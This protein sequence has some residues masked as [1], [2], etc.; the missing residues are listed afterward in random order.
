MVAKCN[1]EEVKGQ[2]SEKAELLQN[3]PE[4]APEAD[5][6]ETEE[7]IK[8]ALNMPGVDE[9]SID[10]S[11]EDDVLT[12]AAS[13]AEDA[14]EGMEEFYRGYREGVY[15]RSFSIMTE[16]DRD[17]IEAKMSNGVLRL[18][19]PKA[20]KPKPQKIAVAID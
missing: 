17:K 14:A 20:E 9:K 1:C 15:K 18:S 13:Q 10:L 12:I 19:L 7:A 3:R 16:I 2:A 5:I 4:F 11:L 8:L 6:Y